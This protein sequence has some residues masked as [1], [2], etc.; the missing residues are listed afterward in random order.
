M[1]LKT[2]VAT[3]KR[4]LNQD[5]QL[6][7]DQILHNVLLSRHMA[8]RKTFCSCLYEIHLAGDKWKYILTIEEACVYLN[9]FN[10]KEVSLISK[11]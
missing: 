8:Q 10:Q 9:H 7:N 6:K 2:S 3:I 5:L 1:S 11:M 4:I